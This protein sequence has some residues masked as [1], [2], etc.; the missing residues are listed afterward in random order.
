MDKRERISSMKN[1]KDHAC[2]SLRILV[3]GTG[4]VAYQAASDR[5]AC[6]T[7]KHLK[8]FSMQ[9][10]DFT[11]Q[12][13]K[14]S[15][16]SGT[17]TAETAPY[18]WISGRAAN[19]KNKNHKLLTTQPKTGNNYQLKLNIKRQGCKQQKRN[20]CSK[21]FASNSML[22]QKQNIRCEEKP[23]N[24]FWLLQHNLQLN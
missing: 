20:S 24:S 8:N 7:D 16:G 15:N 18:L 10:F 12:R 11:V 22:Q 21:N 1:V 23:E 14:T 4:M 9:S 5:V 2:L 3:F 19:I 17:I 13:R 6:S